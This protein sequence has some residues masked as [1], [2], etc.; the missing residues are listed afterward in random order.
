MPGHALPGWIAAALLYRGWNSL[1]LVRLLPA[2][3]ASIPL[4]S[5]LTVLGVAPLA[6][7]AF[8]DRVR[9]EGWKGTVPLYAWAGALVLAALVG[10]FITAGVAGTVT[11]DAERIRSGWIWG[12]EEDL[13][14][15]FA[16]YILFLALE[17]LLLVVLILTVKR[18]PAVL[19]SAAVL[20]VLPAY[21]FGPGN[22]FVMRAPIA[23]L[24]VMALA[25][26]D[27]APW[28]LGRG[29][30]AGIRVLAAMLLLLGCATPLTEIAR[31]IVKPS[32]EPDASRSVVDVKAGGHY[33]AGEGSERLVM[34]LRGGGKPLKATPVE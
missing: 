14:A 15:L 1:R 8:L 13:P 7:A 23:P 32:W 4:W 26:G 11:G 31:V 25:L 18:S 2:I 17:Y 34:L 30:R 28:L 29:A 9:R 10:A 20:A 33:L 27:A 21:S 24:M 19:V 22:D 16:R 6:A 5:P 12:F 3:V